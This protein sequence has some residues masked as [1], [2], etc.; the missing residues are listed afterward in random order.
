V[1][2]YVYGKASLVLLFAT[3]ISTSMERGWNAT[4]IEMTGKVIDK[5]GATAPY[6]TRKGQASKR[7]SPL[8]RPTHVNT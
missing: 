8:A 4:R 3:N 6:D 7:T 5:K 2:L 1:F